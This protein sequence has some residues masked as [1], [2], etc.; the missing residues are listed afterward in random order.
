[1]E[2]VAFAVADCLDALPG[3]RSRAARLAGGG[4]VAPA[5]RALLAT[6]LDVDLYAVD[7]PAAS[8]RGAALLGAYAHDPTTT[9]PEVAHPVLVAT[10]APND[11]LV[12]RRHRYQQQL[13]ALRG[14][15]SGMASS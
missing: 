10:P 3:G 6:V 14:M 12:D 2:G 5:W 13:H 15:P 11:M 4:T 8:A 7:V 9:F 1:M